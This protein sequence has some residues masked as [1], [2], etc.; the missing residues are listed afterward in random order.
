M[1]VAHDAAIDDRRLDLYSLELRYWWQ[2]I[3]VLPAMRRGRHT[4]WP[5]VRALQGQKIQVLT[6]KPRP[7][8]TDGEITTHTPAQF[9]VIPQALA[10]LVPGEI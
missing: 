1:A 3:A 5:G 10:V 9:Q 2:V 4:T 8:N 6:R 7:I